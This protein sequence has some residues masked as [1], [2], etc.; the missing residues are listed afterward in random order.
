MPTLTVIAALVLAVFVP[1]VVS[2]A[3]IVREPE[4]FNVTLNVCVPDTRDAGDGSP[5]LVSDEVSATVSAA[6]ATTF[7]FAST[8]FT[9]TL[10]ALPAVCP[11]GVPALPLLVPGAAVSPG[12]KSCSLA[13]APASTW[14]DGVVEF[15]SDG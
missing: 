2:L 1:S 5:A 12:A 4:V 7:Q 13:N 3:V 15:W 14:S 6:V 9:V 8:P 11:L 10:K